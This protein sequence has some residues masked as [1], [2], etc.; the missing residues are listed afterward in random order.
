MSRDGDTVAFC[1]L[2][3]EQ[4]GFSGGLDG[5]GWDWMGLGLDGT[6]W[7]WMG[8]GGT[9]WDWMGLDGTGTGWDWVGLGGTGWDWMGLGHDAAMRDFSSLTNKQTNK[10]HCVCGVKWEGIVY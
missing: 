2:R 8:L 7:D 10:Q 1:C 9:G 4:D 5:T 6:G 3:E